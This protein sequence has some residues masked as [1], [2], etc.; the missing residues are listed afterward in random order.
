MVSSQFGYVQEPPDLKPD[1]LPYVYIKETV[2]AVVNTQLQ[3]VVIREEMSNGNHKSV[4]KF[5]R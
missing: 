4:L 1:A 2:G 3:F 5:M